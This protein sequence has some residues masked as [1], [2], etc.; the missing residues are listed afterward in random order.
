MQLKKI[1]NNSF[2]IITIF[3]PYSH[4]VASNS[5]GEAAGVLLEGTNLLTKFFWAGCI[6]CGVFLLTAALSNY[7]EHRNNPKLVP[8]STV[9]TYIILGIIVIMIP[10]LNRLFGSDAY[11][12]VQGINF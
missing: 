10:I 8:M 7:R 1:I 2:W 3:F 12:F 9:I 11:D 6:F 4:L 5:I